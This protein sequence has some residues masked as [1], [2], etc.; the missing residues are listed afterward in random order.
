MEVNGYCQLFGYHYSSKY[1]LMQETHTV[2]EL[3]EGDRIFIIGRT[4]P[5]KSPLKK[6]MLLLKQH[7]VIDLFEIDIQIIN[8]SFRQK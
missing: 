1:L 2:L 5:F 3:V 4:I 8:I 6:E 7:T